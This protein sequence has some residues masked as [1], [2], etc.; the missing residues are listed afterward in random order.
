MVIQ[1]LRV[2]YPFLVSFIPCEALRKKGIIIAIM[3]IQLLRFVSLVGTKLFF[4]CKVQVV[5]LPL[6]KILIKNNF[7]PTRDTKRSNYCWNEAFI[8]PYLQK[9]DTKIKNKSA[10]MGYVV[11]YRLRKDTPCTPKR[12]TLYPVP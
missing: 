7:V 4:I 10:I 1:L 8:I 9:M 12:Y 11:L 3:V 6:H 5:S 2:Y